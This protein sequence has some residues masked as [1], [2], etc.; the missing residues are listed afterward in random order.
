MGKRYEQPSSELVELIDRVRGDYYA[1]E[2]ENVTIGALFIDDD[3]GFPCLEHQGYPAAAVCRIVPARDRAA[4]L[5]DA[6][7]I[8]DL[9][10]Y[11]ELN[12]RQ[13][14]A[15]LDHELHHIER[16]RDKYGDYK[17]DAQGRPALEIRKHDWNLGWFDEVANRHGE[18]SIEVIQARRLLEQSGQLYFDFGKR[19]A[20]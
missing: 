9:C 1:D 14:I 2:L 16:K 19:A 18:N 4:G 8:V 12:A 17:L 20:A 5:P 10:T 7:I 11:K 13:K 15:L 3:S 6:Q